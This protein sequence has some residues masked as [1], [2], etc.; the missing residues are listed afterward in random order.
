MED[1]LKNDVEAVVAKIFSEKE[2]ADIRKQTEKALST[3]AVTIE[4]LTV[5]L[6]TKNSEVLELTEQLSEAKEKATNLESDLEAVKEEMEEAKKRSTELE[7]TLEEIEKDRATELRITELEEAGVISDK[8]AQMSKVREMSDEDFAS[9]KDELV[10]VRAA[11]IAE[12]SKSEEKEKK[13]E[14]ETEEKEETEEAETEEKE[15]A[16]TE[17]K[18]ET[19]EAEKEEDAEEKET[20]PAN[21]DK[22]QAVEAALNLELAAADDIKNKYQKLGTAMADLLIKE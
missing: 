10:A 15:E 7:G 22:N 4:D 5:T 11:I 20:P 16:D 12:L 13:E 18:E 17:E 3:A 1:K 14:S 9:Y 19:E 2:E 6:E 21:I 8:E